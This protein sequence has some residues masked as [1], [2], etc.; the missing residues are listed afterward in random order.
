MFKFIPANDGKDH[1]NIYTKG[2]TELGRMLSNLYD[3]KFEVPG[4]GRFNSLE[5]FWYYYLTGCRFEEL[6]GMGGFKA[7]SFGRTKCQ[8]RIDDEEIGVVGEHREVILEAIRCKLR[9]NRNILKLLTESTLPLSHYYAKPNREFST[10]YNIAKF[11]WQVEEFERLRNIMRKHIGL[12]A[13]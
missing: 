8:Y 2:K 11:V 6:K 4:Y 7:K 9:Q 1:I 12:E 10:H 3:C 13:C 5:G